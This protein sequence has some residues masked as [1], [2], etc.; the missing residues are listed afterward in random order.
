LFKNLISRD[1]GSEVMGELVDPP[2]MD[3]STTEDNLS[4]TDSPLDH[5]LDINDLTPSEKV[6]R[7]MALKDRGAVKFKDG[8]FKDAHQDYQ[9]A[10]KFVV[11]ATPPPPEIVGAI[12]DD[13]EPVEEPVDPKK[14]ID[15]K[16]AL[17]LNIAACL[18]KNEK[19][20]KKE[21]RIIACC[22]KVL[23]LDASSVK[24]LYR[25]AKAWADLGEWQ[26]AQKDLKIA[27][28]VEPENKALK[29]ELARA[30][31][32]EKDY[33]SIMAKR[34]ANMFVS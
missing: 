27:L 22:S 25:R 10:F 6:D 19:D 33:N 15:L 7:A 24:A 5:Y 34:M 21:Q 17:Y 13:T 1:D 2:T 8:L 14:I 20:S 3:S 30:A 26:E 32:K 29:T 18:Q 16:C 11:S 31:K 4:K 9:Q 12:T 23:A 28:E